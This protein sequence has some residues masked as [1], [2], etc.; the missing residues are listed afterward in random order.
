M[1]DVS[2]WTPLVV[3]VTLAGLANASLLLDGASQM[4]T[5]R[6]GFLPFERL[7]FK[8]VPA[9]EVDCVRQGG[10]RILQAL[11]AIFILVPMAAWM[12]AI[13]ADLT[14]RAPS[15]HLPSSVGD[16]LFGLA[17]AS[18]L[19]GLALSFGSYAIST[20]IKY[21]STSEARSTRT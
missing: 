21:I 20:K 4:A 16:A 14:G 7:L 17:V 2:L 19:I 9:S 13:T 15:T 11:S 12:L 8:R 5:G 6:P 3:V 1:S 10:S 18:L